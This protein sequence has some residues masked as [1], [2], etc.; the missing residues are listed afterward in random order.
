MWHELQGIPGYHA[1]SAGTVTLPKGAILL[2]IV[3]HSTGAGTVTI[4][5]G[6]SLPV[7]GGAAPTELR[8][9]HTM[10]LSRNDAAFA[11]SQDIVFTGTDSYFVHWCYPAHT[12]G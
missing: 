1:G 7:I 12:S 2:Q 4:F 11:G 9:N 6:D 10:W 8:F 3:V 5:G